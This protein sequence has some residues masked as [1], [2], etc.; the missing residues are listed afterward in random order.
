LGLRLAARQSPALAYQGPNTIIF[1]IPGS[2]PHTIR[3]TSAL[4]AIMNPVL[5]DGTTQPGFAGAPIIELDGSL[6]DG[7]SGLVIDGGNSTV[8]GLVINRFSGDGVVLQ[9]GGN[10]VVQGNYIGTDVSGQIAQ[11]NGA[12][13][14]LLLGGTQSNRIGTDGDGVNDAAEPNI[15]SANGTQVIEIEGAGTNQNVVAGNHIG[16]DVTGTRPLGNGNGVWIHQGAQ[17]NRIGVQSTDPGLCGGRQPDRGQ[18]LFGG[19]SLQ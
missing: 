16:T 10:N 6:A 5:I 13:G 9:L 2:G 4:P 18:C 17:G 8:Q 14:V 12:A 1:Q 15:V 7:A 11:G 3:P 19:G